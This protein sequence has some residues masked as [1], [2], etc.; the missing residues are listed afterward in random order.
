MKKLISA[1]AVASLF[2]SANAHAAPIGLELSLVIDISGS[3]SSTE[4]NTQI[5]GYKNAFLD[6]TV[7]SNILSYTNGVAVNVIQFGSNAAQTIGWTLLSTAT[8]ILNF[9]T[10]IG[11]MTR[12]TTIGSST[13]VEDGML[14]GISSI[15]GNNYTGGRMVIDVSGDGY[16]NT[17]P[18]CSSTPTVA[19]ASTQ[20]ARDAA[21]AG[22]ITINGLAIEGDMGT[23]GVTTWYNT[24]VRTSNGFVYTAAGFDDFERA[25]IT[26]IGAETHGV[27]EPA[28][29]ALLGLG[30]AGLGMA[31][32]R[33]QV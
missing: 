22:G 31:R 24:N 5:N 12:L 3:V 4:Y 9:A 7:Q 10:S 1:I 23:L 27:P 11:S 17:D 29:L 15:L 20:A 19:C 2:A 28:S 25:V 13:D 16:Q 8:D 6:S 18:S 32:R 33:K 21:F 26:K 30:L 14:L